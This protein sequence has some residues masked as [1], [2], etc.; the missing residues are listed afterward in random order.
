MRQSLRKSTNMILQFLMARY[1]EKKPSNLNWVKS[2]SILV[3]SVGILEMSRE[4]LNVMQ[5]QL[6]VKCLQSVRYLFMILDQSLCYP[7]NLTNGIK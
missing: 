5:S 6:T 2:Y 4:N 1:Y 7:K 3:V